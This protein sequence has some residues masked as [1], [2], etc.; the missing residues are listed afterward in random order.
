METFAALADSTRRRI[1]EL[2]ARREMSAGEVAAEFDC[3]GPAISHHLKVLR[4]VGLIRQRVAAQHRFYMLDPAGFDTLDA[5]V[6]EQRRFWEKQLDR[7]EQRIR[8]DVAA[9]TLPAVSRSA[10]PRRT[11]KRRKS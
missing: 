11:R 8:Q 6:A 5:W 3:T 10:T 1:V 4:E 9:G 2:L 7:L